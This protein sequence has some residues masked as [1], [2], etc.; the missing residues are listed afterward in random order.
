ML[1]L[2]TVDRPTLLTTDASHHENTAIFFH[3]RKSKGK[4][5]LAGDVFFFLPVLQCDYSNRGTLKNEPIILE[6]KIAAFFVNE[7]MALTNANVSLTTFN[8]ADLSIG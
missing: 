4:D 6:Q 5:Q 7:P 8:V 1:T 3:C 2:F